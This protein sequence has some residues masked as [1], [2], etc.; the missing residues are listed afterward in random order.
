MLI[1]CHIH[2]KKYSPDSHMDLY[3]AINRAKLLGLD[4]LCVTNHDNLSIREEIGDSSVVNGVLVLVGAEVL[5][6]EGDILTFG[7]KNIPKE[8]VSAE[9]LLTMVKKDNGVAIAAHPFRNNNRGLG[10]SIERLFNL[11]SGIEAFNGN[12]M[13]QHNL[14]AY[15]VG[16][17]LGLP[18]FGASDAH[19][20]ERLGS[21]ATHFD[22]N[23]RD[24]RDFIDA[25]KYSSFYPVQLINK[26]YE[27]VSKIPNYTF[28]KDILLEI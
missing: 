23:I 3:D 8:K 11:L 4:G 10:Y 20:V 9:K 12:T 27:K 5:T 26:S 14:Q 16:K 25:V 18:L 22:N 6:F 13:E 1:D 28:Q 21:Y 24:I 7:L 15:N 2:E 17:D 19:K